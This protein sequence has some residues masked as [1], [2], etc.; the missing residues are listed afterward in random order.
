MNRAQIKQLNR[1]ID[2]LLS[3][4][5]LPTLEGL[6]IPIELK[7]KYGISYCDK[8]KDITDQDLDYMIENES[9]T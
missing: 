1:R 4:K 6:Y 9:K 2:E 7:I 8:L 5:K 3:R